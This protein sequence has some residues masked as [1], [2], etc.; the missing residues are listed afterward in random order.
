M[1]LHILPLAVTMMAGPQIMSDIIFITSPRPVPTNGAFVVGVAIAAT[2]GTAIATGLVSL[3]GLDLGDSSDSGSAGTIIQVALVALLVLAAIKNVVRRETI[4]PPKWLGALQEA[5]QQKAFKTGLLVILAMP[6]DII[7]MLTVGTNLQQT[8]SSF[9][10]ALPF[11][12]A[13]VLVAALPLLGY[14]LFRR[15]AQTAMPKV[16]DWMNNNAWAVNVIVCGIFLL[17]ILV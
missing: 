8:N 15:R 9:A 6:S 12:G 5:D 1:S 7:I 16:R 10:A 17:L 3:L 2:A 4:E 13:T 11:I 14:L